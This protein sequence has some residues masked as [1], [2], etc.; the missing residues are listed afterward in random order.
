MAT[1]SETRKGSHRAE[2]AQATRQAF[3]AAARQLFTEKG[4]AATPTEE[5]IDRAGASRGALYHHFRDKTDLF[6]AVFEEI[7]QD[8]SEHITAAAS[9]GRDPMA[10]IRHGIDA[11]LDRCL[12]P[13]VQRIA[14]LEAPSVLGWD[15]WQEIDQ[16]Y[17]FGLVTTGLEAAMDAGQIRKQPLEPLAHLVMG[18]LTQAGLALARADDP[19]R[20]RKQFGDAMRSLVNGLQKSTSS[21]GT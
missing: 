18:A 12:D 14:L 3:L 13:D 2:R 15:Q 7:E 4:F 1:T 8:L 11:F 9:R 16:R 17:A 5:I 19:V 6:R 21:V 20:Q 10:Q